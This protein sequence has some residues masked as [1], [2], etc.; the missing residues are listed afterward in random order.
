MF[1]G[2]V[3]YIGIAGMASLLLE[4]NLPNAKASHSHGGQALKRRLFRRLHS[5]SPVPGPDVVSRFKVQKDLKSRFKVH[6]WKTGPI[7]AICHHV[8]MC[9]SMSI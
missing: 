2:N 3:T 1:F 7:F 8:F 9:M 4:L 6:R 5:V